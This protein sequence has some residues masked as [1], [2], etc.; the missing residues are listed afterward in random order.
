MYQFPD[1]FDIKQF[2]G[3]IIQEIYFSA[4]TVSLITGHSRWFMFTGRFIF[5]D[6][7]EEIEFEVYPVVSDFGLLKLVGQTIEKI[8]I[9]ELD[10]SLLIYFGN[11]MTLNL[12][13]SRNYESIT[14]KFDDHD[15]I[16]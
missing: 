1:S 3:A 15:I 10:S 12:L 7:Q 2:N 6:C 14:I 5:N 11:K 13:S 9:D 8:V 16:I 4:S